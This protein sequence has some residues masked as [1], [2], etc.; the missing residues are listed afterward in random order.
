M[1]IT[2]NTE[3]FFDANPEFEF[4]SG[5][6]SNSNIIQ[7]GVGNTYTHD[8]I[9][10]SY[11]SDHIPVT[12]LCKAFD[13]L[14]GTTFE[15]KARD[16]ITIFGI[17]EGANAIT[18]V[19]SQE[20]ANVPVAN[21]SSGDVDTPDFSSTTNEIKVFEGIKEL[22]Y[23]GFD[24]IPGNTKEKFYITSVKVKNASDDLEIS[25]VYIDKNRSNIG[26]RHQQLS[27]FGTT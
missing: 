22:T 20:F 27:M 25:S 23:G 13:S 4:Y 10:G 1:T 8:D 17:K 12:I 14:D 7:S 6:F 26:G 3:N 19:Q 9:P 15:E 11:D 16:Q 5:D 18:F 21:S 24:T 2:A